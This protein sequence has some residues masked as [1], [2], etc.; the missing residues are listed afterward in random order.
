M[1]GYPETIAIR[2][3]MSHP[4]DPQAPSPLALLAV[5]TAFLLVAALGF[6]FASLQTSGGD[7]S[8]QAA[9]CSTKTFHKGGGNCR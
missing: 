7:S 4:S 3:L 5:V 1:H 9:A 8:P 2:H 6:A